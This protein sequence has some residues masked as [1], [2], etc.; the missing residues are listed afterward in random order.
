MPLALANRVQETATAN[1]TVSFT[2]TGAVAGFQSF[3]VIGD[4]NTTYYSATDGAGNWEVGLGTYSTT[5]PTLTRTTVYASSNSNSAVIFSGVVNVFVTYPSGRSVNLNEAGNVS[6][7]GT[8]SSGIWQGSTVGVAYGGTG[9]TASSG[10]NSVVLRDTNQNISVNRANQAN[11]TVNA[12]GVPVSLNA[13][14]AATQT[15]VGTPFVTQIVVT[16]NA[17]TLSAGTIFTINN[18]TTNTIRIDNFANVQIGSIAS[19]GAAQLILI[20]NTNIDGVW[21]IHAFL[22]EGVT[23]GTNALNMGATVVSGGTWQGGTV[24]P[25]YGGTGLTTFVGANNALYSTGANTLTAGTLPVAAGGTGTP[26]P[27]LVGGTNVTISGSW[28]NQTVSASGGGGG[29]L[30]VGDIIEADVAPSTGTWLATGGYYS[31]ATYPTLA[32]KLGSIPDFTKYNTSS[33]QNNLIYPNAGN[34]ATLASNTGRYIVDNDGTK[35]VFASSGSTVTP[36]IFGGYYSADGQNY[37]VCNLGPCNELRYVGGKWIGC[38]T[39]VAFAIWTSNDGIA[40]RQTA[41]NG[42]LAATALNSVAFGNGVWVVVSGVGTYLVSTDGENWQRYVGMWDTSISLTFTQRTTVRLDRVR[43]AAGRFVAVGTETTSFTGVAVTSTDGINWTGPGSFGAGSRQLNHL[44][45]GNS[46]WVAAG[47]QNDIRSSPDGLTW[48]LRSSGFSYTF[49]KL[50]FEN[51]LFVAVGDFGIIRTSPDG[52]TWTTQT[53]PI[54]DGPVYT[55]VIWTGSQ[56]IASVSGGGKWITS[57]DGVTWTAFQDA[58]GKNPIWNIAHFSGKTTFVSPGVTKV[59]LGTTPVAISQGEASLGGFGSTSPGQVPIAFG[60]G[61]YV[62]VGAFGTI[63]YSSAGTNWTFVNTQTAATISNIQ[64]INGYFLAAALGAFYYSTDGINW[65]RQTYSLAPAASIVKFAYLASSGNY[66][67][68]T[69]SGIGYSNNLI[70]WTSGVASGNFQDII[71]FP[72]SS[73]LVAG[74]VGGAIQTSPDGVTW[75]NRSIGGGN[76]ITKWVYGSA[77]T[78]RLVGAYGFNVVETADAITFNSRS[79]GL[80]NSIADICWDAVIG[81]TAI[82]TTATNFR[83]ASSTTGV[84]WTLRQT[85]LNNNIT[86]YRIFA[87]G[88]NRIVFST[89]GLILRTPD[90]GQTWSSVVSRTVNPIST[91]FS[92]RGIDFVNGR[93]FYISNGPGAELGFFATSTD[94]FTWSLVGPSPSNFVGLP[95]R[96]YELNGFSYITSSQGLHY[97]TD[98]TNW[99]RIFS[100]PSDVVHMAYGGGIWL[101]VTAPTFG[102]NNSSGLVLVY[103]ST[104]GVNF[105]Y[106]A[107]VNIPIRAANVTAPSATDLVYASGRFCI[108]FA[109]G[110]FTDQGIVSPAYYSTDGV[111]WLDSTI[112]SSRPATNGFG[113]VV[114]TDGTTILALPD[115]AGTFYASALKSTD[116]GQ[117]F[118]TGP[119]LGL[120]AGASGAVYSNG[121][122][123]TLTTP[124]QYLSKDTVN[125]TTPGINITLASN[126]YVTNNAL[127]A[128]SINSTQRVGHNGSVTTNIPNQEFQPLITYPSPFVVKGGDKVLT[129]SGFAPM[130]GSSSYVLEL[131]FYSYN[132]STTFYVPQ[133]GASLN[134]WIYA[135]P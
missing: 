77:P 73:V 62:C 64:F 108:F 7:L 120:A 19:G 90:A 9:V 8:V 71:F 118:T 126:I 121:V 20:D 10:A 39:S 86:P 111:T 57:P 106:A 1:T 103:K 56:F 53:S 66:V 84:T 15:F 96:I 27:S 101:C 82:E 42:S 119:R 58:D 2:L 44:A 105:S 115:Q 125:W 107:N 30:Q 49:Y 34:S 55:D 74:G 11:N 94:T 65:T 72:P 109:T 98:K 132:T 127:Y 43:F 69:S 67:A 17:T 60:A 89:Q 25:A 100:V 133:G 4:T 104:D 79:T 54:L 97:S 52:I 6:A 26:T 124:I 13:A 16:P 63:A 88:I 113:G 51:G 18:V 122:W 116:G 33:G 75:T 45:Y 130:L 87:D 83:L 129:P 48:T 85:L 112:P 38:G 23:W 70:T 92:A 50:I 41:L 99:T 81:F 80:S 95:R 123:L 114:A 32:A 5:G 61:V 29:G 47:G 93:W 24:Q 128:A 110:S 91:S 35:I 12:T 131:Q 22:P 31:K 59:Q 37:S 21:D 46:I 68:I 134:S 14:S 135:G 117:T 40:W 102:I 76:T 3:S 78:F 36:N 28:P